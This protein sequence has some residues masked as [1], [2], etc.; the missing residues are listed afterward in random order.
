MVACEG[1]ECPQAYLR[2]LGGICFTGVMPIMSMSFIPFLTSG[3]R[4]GGSA[5]LATNPIRPKLGSV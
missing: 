1:D 5:V 4:A 2:A 3:C